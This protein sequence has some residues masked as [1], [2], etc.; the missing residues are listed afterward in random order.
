MA[1][2]MGLKSLWDYDRT[3]DKMLP[4]FNNVQVLMIRELFKSWKH[5]LFY[6]YKYPTSKELFLDTIRRLHAIGIEVVGIVCDMG[7]SFAP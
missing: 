7:I 4:P 6:G 1:Y 3:N 2:E 5:P